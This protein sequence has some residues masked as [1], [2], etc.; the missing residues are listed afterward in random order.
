M[1]LVLISLFM[2]FVPM[3]GQTDSGIVKLTDAQRDSVILRIQWST[4]MSKCGRI[5]IW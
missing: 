1:N 2:T 4:D 5:Q 3:W